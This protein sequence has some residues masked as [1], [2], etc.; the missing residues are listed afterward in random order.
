MRGYI[1]S[2]HS[3]KP[4]KFNREFSTTS[5]VLLGADMGKKSDS[6]GSS[7]SGI[8]MRELQERAQSRLRRQAAGKQQN[9]LAQP[10]NRWQRAVRYN[11]DKNR[12]RG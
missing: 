2:Y 1:P 9:K 12:G 7:S 5:C 6:S 4:I 10:Q 8:T 11:W 3:K